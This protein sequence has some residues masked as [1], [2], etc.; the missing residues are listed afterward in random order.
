MG[1][2][3]ADERGKLRHMDLKKESRKDSKLELIFD[4]GHVIHA[5]IQ[6]SYMRNYDSTAKCD[7]P[8]ES[9]KDYNIGGTADQVIR[10]QDG[11][12]YVID[13]K[14]QRTEKFRSTNTIADISPKYIGQINLYMYAL[15]V[16]GCILFFNKNDQS[17]KEFFFDKPDMR[18]VN[19]MLALAKTATDFINGKTY[20]KI[21]QEC[22]AGEG[23]YL[24][25]PYAI[26]CMKCKTLDA[27]KKITKGTV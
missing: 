3:L 11:N 1:F 9:L 18:I 7:V 17:M 4:V 5:L 24:D 20:V 2:G 13:Y 22:L 21:L 15:K 26:H 12:L 14:T 8:I 19:A 10:L 25:C 27:I 6:E 23:M 16:R